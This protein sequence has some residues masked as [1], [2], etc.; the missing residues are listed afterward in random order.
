MKRISMWSGPRN[1]STAIMYSFRQ[2]PD[3]VVIDE[4]LY[5][6]YLEQSQKSHPGRL[7]VLASQDRDINLLKNNVIFKDFRQDILFLKNMAHHLINLD[8]S[9]LDDLSNI[10]LTRDPAE[11]LPSLAKNIEQPVLQ[12]T[13]LSEQNQILDYVLAKGQSPIVLDAKETLLNPEKVLSELCARLEIPFYQEML[14]WP[15]GAKPEDG[16]WAK[17]W[18]HNVHKS[19]GFGRYQAKTDALPAE[20]HELYNE[21][22]PLYERLYSY[23]IKAL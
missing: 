4:P 10:I 16:I 23:A 1:V 20:L 12:D 13:G 5:A 2:R 8:F 17:Y 9:L 21:A 19:T 3:T 22:K 18:Y 11:M 14:S 6:Y 7:E 15:A